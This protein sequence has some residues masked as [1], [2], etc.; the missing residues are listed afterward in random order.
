VISRNSCI[1][2]DVLLNKENTTW[3]RQ[4]NYIH[5]CNDCVRQEK[6]DWATKARKRHP[7]LVSERSRRYKEKQRQENPKKYSALQMRHS[8]RKRANA[9]ALPFDLSSEFVLS[10]CFDTCPILGF[11]LKYGGGE[12]SK[13]SASLDR[14]IPSL[15]YTK[16]NVMVVSLL[17]NTM[18]NEATP[19]E[20]IKFSEWIYET[21]EK[22]LGV[23][24]TG[25]KK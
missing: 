23:A 24:R 5:K 20:M 12:K 19:K 13:Y 10:I 21:Y 11:H 18:K 22:R 25:V 17:A 7:G 2:C 8:A 16:D 4:K 14:I 9:L 15:G 3:Y 6:R 1:V